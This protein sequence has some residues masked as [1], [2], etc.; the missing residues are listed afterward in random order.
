MRYRWISSH[1]DT[2]SVTTMC[3]V[4]KAS[5]SSYRD[6]VREVFEQ[7]EGSYRSRKFVEALDQQI[8]F[9]IQK[10]R[11]GRSQAEPFRGQALFLHTLERIIS[12][13]KGLSKL[14]IIQFAKKPS[15]EQ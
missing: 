10:A 11:Q 12:V 15:I 2:F 9:K 7:S 5:R 4:L 6:R 13:L 3:R 14:K 1:R 8:D